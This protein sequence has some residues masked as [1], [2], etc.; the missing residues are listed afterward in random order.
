MHRLIVLVATLAN[1]VVAIH[2]DDAFTSGS[3]PFALAII[4]T[5]ACLL[6]VTDRSR[7]KVPEAAEFQGYY[8]I[9]WAIGLAVWIVSLFVPTPWRYVVWGIALAIEIGT[10]LLSVVRI[11]T[12]PLVSSHIAERFGL[13]TIIVLGESVVSVAAGISDVNFAFQSSVVAVGTFVLAAA[14]WWQYFDCV[15]TVHADSTWYVYLHGPLYAGL[16]L[17]APGALLAIDGAEGR[18]AA[19]RCARG[20]VRRNRHLPVRGVRDRAGQP[21]A[22]GGPPPGGHARRHRRPSAG[23]RVPR[24]RAQ[25]GGHDPAA[26]RRR[27]GR[28]L[29]RA[30]P[31]QAFQSGLSPLGTSTVVPSCE[32]ANG[33]VPSNGGPCAS[34]G[35]SYVW[36]ELPAAILRRSS[37][38]SSVASSTPCSRATSRSVRPDEAAS[39]TISAALS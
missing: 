1:I 24:R 16:G 25:P 34:A 19:R 15:T 7:R 8:E 30:Q 29:L 6:A 2:V 23:H 33:A 4:A 26:R 21:P 36:A 10:P 27:G 9:R 12:L 18:D 13:F 14:V 17:V 35:R 20:A 5:R 32:S 28:A 37:A 11:P 22:A 38:L 31:D 39:L 3:E